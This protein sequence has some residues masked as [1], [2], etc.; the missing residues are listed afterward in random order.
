MG[1]GSIV[2]SWRV[3]ESGWWPLKLTVRVRRLMT[4]RMLVLAPPVVVLLF[5]CAPSTNDSVARQISASSSASIDS[6]G[7][8]VTRSPTPEEQ[9]SLNAASSA[10][11]SVDRQ[12]P[13]PAGPSR[14]IKLYRVIAVAKDLTLTLDDAHRIRIDGIECSSEGV[15]YIDRMLMDSDSRVA[16]LPFT[17][18]PAEPVPSEVW[19]VDVAESQ[20]HTPLANYSLIAETALTSGWCTPLNTQTSPHYERY[21]ALAEL[22]RSNKRLERP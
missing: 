6:S 14:E 9:A 15:S 20:G 19:L 12:Y 17:S 8:V 21:R 11:V 18:Q 7:A 16:F 3:I 22:A 2:R 4:P 10:I 13:R 1:A 5:G